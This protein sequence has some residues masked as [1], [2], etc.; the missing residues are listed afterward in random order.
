VINRFQVSLL[1][2][3]VVALLSACGGGGGG[4][5]PPAST[6]SGQSSSGTTV[7]FTAQ[8]N[9]TTVPFSSVGGYSGTLD[10]PGIEGLGSVSVAISATAPSS[11]TPI[12]TRVRAKNARRTDTSSNGNP[13]PLLYITLTPVNAIQFLGTLGATVTAP[14]NPAGSNPYVAVF[15]ANEANEW[16]LFSDPGAVA[17]STITIS[18]IASATA[19]IDLPAGQPTYF[20]V[21][22]A[23]PA[24]AAITLS[25]PLVIASPA[26]VNVSVALYDMFSAPITGALAQPIT[27]ADSDTTGVTALQSTS[28]TQTSQ[29]V[30]LTYNGKADLFKLSVSGPVSAGQTFFTTLNKEQLISGSGTTPPNAIWNFILGSDGNFWSYSSGSYGMDRITP[31]AVYTY[32]ADPTTTH[33]SLTYAIAEGSD[34]NAWIAYHDEGSETDGISKVTPSGSYTSYPLSGAFLNGTSIDD[35]ALGPD[36]AI[37]FS[38]APE[39]TGGT[40]GIGR[41][42]TSGNMSDF[43]LPVEP[44]NIITG[45]DGNLWFNEGGNVAKMTT[46][47]ALTTYTLP[48]STSVGPALA[49]IVGP[50]GNFWAPFAY[51]S[52]NLLKFNTSG[53]YVS[54]TALNYTSPSG[55]SQP[56]WI[57]NLIEVSGNVFFVDQNNEAVGRI[58]ASGNVIAYPMYSTLTAVIDDPMRI[59][60]GTNGQLYVASMA[61]LNHT[62]AGIVPA[63][64]AISPSD[65]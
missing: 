40:T 42:D 22:E 11:I 25:S 8:A 27:V 26:T 23:P 64:T 1:F 36:G 32:F 45:P 39:Y 57:G 41:I 5:A 62:Q 21:F 30:P 10:L 53:A 47:G 34:G 49:F 48:G 63:L 54:S 51:G 58:D 56:P 50:D 13:V 19:A 18:S 14:S 2:A 52:G 3:L 17:G 44:S 55:G 16:T 43:P 12:S 33:E 29:T 61:V 4:A 24:S 28:I 6:S 9:P 38:V 46:A 65:W 35:I 59:E 37:W 60:L 31:S 20:A 7:N 15:S